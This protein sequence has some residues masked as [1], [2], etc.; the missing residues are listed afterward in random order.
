VTSWD[1]AGEAIWTVGY[2]S[3]TAK[4]R[5]GAFVDL[6]GDGNQELAYPT[7]DGRLLMLDPGDPAST[8]DQPVWVHELPGPV[9]L[10]DVVAADM[11]SDGGPDLVFAAADGVLRALRAA[12]GEPLW[13]LDLGKQA[14]HPVLG[15]VDCDGEVEVLVATAGELHAVDFGQPAQLRVDA[16]EVALSIPFARDGQLVE[17][18][19]TVRNL[20]SFDANAVPVHLRVD[21]VAYP[22][23]LL[24]V[25]GGGAK[26]TATWSW[27][28]EAGRRA[29]EVVA[30]GVGAGDPDE[31][32]NRAVRWFWVRP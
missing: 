5:H 20:G 23:V 12:N 16:S 19:A 27:R 10:T 32:D 9:T 3:E 26:A 29:L 14:Y 1:R 31:S 6:D 13:S 24:N 17:V 4:T 18:S 7:A 25:P 2:E 11:D 21:G 22:E 8:F 28:A 30:E 15:D